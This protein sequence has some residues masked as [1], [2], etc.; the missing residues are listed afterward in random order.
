MDWEEERD[1][2]CGRPVKVRVVAVAATKT[3][4]LVFLDCPCGKTKSFLEKF[5]N[6]KLNSKRYTVEKSYLKLGLKDKGNRE[7]G[8]LK[9]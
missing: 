8:L 5:F 3:E 9:K 1:C 7:G 6:G 4:V 2:P